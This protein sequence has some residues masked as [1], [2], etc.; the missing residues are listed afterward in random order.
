MSDKTEGLEMRMVHVRAFYPADPVG[1]V[2][3]GVD[4]F[5]RGILK[6]APDDIRFSLVGMTTDVIARPL[7]QWTRCT[8]GERE[9][10]FFPVVAVKASGQRT[11]FPLSVRYTAAT[12]R[13]LRA[14]TRDFDVFEFHRVEPGLLFLRDPRPKNAFFHQDMAV[15]HSHRADI[16]W[17][18]LP[19]LY[20][21]VERRVM[22][23]LSS[24]WCVR[25]EG[26]TAMRRRYPQQAEHIR[27]IPT[28]VDTDVFSPPAE[29][30]RD[31]LRLELAS[32]F[33]IDPAARWIVSVGRLDRQKDPGLLL[34]SFARLVAEGLDVFWL[35]VGDG[36]L[37]PGLARQVQE[38]GLA[39]RVRFLGLRAPPYIA[40]L[41]RA[42]D[43]FA[44]S[45]AY[46]GMPM[47]LLEALGSG[48]PV[49]TTD[50]GE[51]HRVVNPGVNGHIA[52]TADVQSFADCLAK[53]LLDSSHLRGEAAV[54][55]IQAFRPA[56]VLAPVY[57]NYRLLIH[58]AAD[59]SGVLG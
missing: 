37:R 16:L 34:G 45:S 14:L 7:S 35:A 49:A 46:E 17:R 57:E 19:G 15:I 4:T 53:T 26:V 52:E 22:A 12:A 39:S 43:V 51:V 54:Q 27:F 2:P 18:H 38:A 47:A 50:V 31:A 9:F 41:L 20:F 24:A 44:L 56:Q 13:Q 59:G 30:T 5:L 32:E 29:D 58:A 11:R 36:V 8:I 1:I 40:D 3:G 10:D 42:A 48:L 25:Q 55:S 21:W 28:W 6:F 23:G 33:L